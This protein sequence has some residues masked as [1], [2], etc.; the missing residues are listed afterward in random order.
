MDIEKTEQPQEALASDLVKYLRLRT[1]AEQ[2][3]KNRPNLDRVLE[4][5][6]NE[7]NVGLEL[8]LLQWDIAS[9]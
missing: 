6:L 1:E 9:L 4:R 3:R 8:S 2:F 7:R 5:L